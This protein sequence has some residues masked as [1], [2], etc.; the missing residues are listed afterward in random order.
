MAGD[1]REPP[2]SAPL[3]GT[4]GVIPSPL[5]AHEPLQSTDSIRLI[6]IHA[7]DLNAKVTLTIIQTHLRAAPPYEAIS[8]TWGDRTDLQKIPCGSDSTKIPVTKSCE[9]VLRRLRRL[10]EDRLVWIDA[11][12]IDQTNINERNAQLAIMAQIYQLA[13]RLPIVIMLWTP[14]CI[15]PRS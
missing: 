8:Y 2:F 14:S 3:I 5:F 6:Q 1:P 11:L 15:A 4:D 9:S 7:G 10:K 12:C 13:R